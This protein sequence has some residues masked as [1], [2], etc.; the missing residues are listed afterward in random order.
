MI[1]S[2]SRNNGIKEFRGTDE[3]TLSLPFT[4]IS[5]TAKVL[6]GSLGEG[7]KDEIGGPEGKGAETVEGSKCA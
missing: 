3:R 1:D 6:A 2:L 4:W 5:R 7:C